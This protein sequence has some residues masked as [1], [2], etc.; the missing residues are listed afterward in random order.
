[1]SYISNKENAFKRTLPVLK[2]N[3]IY[4]TFYFETIVSLN[5]EVFA[6]YVVWLKYR[7]AVALLAIRVSSQEVKGRMF[8]YS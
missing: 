6:D 5:A 7:I 3:Q 8:S 2:K 1:M 4:K